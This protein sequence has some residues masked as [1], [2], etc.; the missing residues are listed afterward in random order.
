MLFLLILLTIFFV[1][2]VSPMLRE[3]FSVV[4][5]NVD[6]VSSDTV[7]KDSTVF[8]NFFATINSNIPLDHSDY[9]KYPD[10]SPFPFDADFKNAII[11]LVS[12]LLTKEPRYNNTNFIVLRSIYNIYSKVLPNDQIGYVFNADLNNPIV[13]FVKKLKVWCRI[14][15]ASTYFLSN[16]TASP[17]AKQINKNDLRIM[18]ITI[19]ETSSSDFSF[20]AIDEL[21]SDNYRILNT[22]FLM[23]PFLTSGQDMIIKPDMKIAFQSVLNDK[24]AALTSLLNSAKCFGVTSGSTLIDCQTQGGVWDYPATQDFDCPFFQLNKNYPNTFGKQTNGYC[25]VPLNT[26]LLGFKITDPK[27]QPLCYNCKSNITGPGTLG[28][29]CNEQKHPTLY[30]TLHSPDYAFPGDN[31]LR[32]QYAKQLGDNGLSV[33]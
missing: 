1:V 10:S 28:A 15:N 4:P 31:S 24:Q 22:L 2:L 7:D 32:Q 33:L 27:S 6:N 12:P 14:Q 8:M 26:Q 5:S 21:S 23:D 3:T 9:T 18:Y 11:S 20:T 25:E 17:L 19:Q 30:P 29:C 16:G 13:P